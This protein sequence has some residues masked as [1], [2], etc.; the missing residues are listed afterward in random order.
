M[1][2]PKSYVIEVEEYNTELYDDKLN[3]M[4]LS[5]SKEISYFSTGDRIIEFPFNEDSSDNSDIL[6]LSKKVTMQ[7]RIVYD[8]FMMFGDVG[9]LNDFLILACGSLFGFF[10]QRF[11]LASLVE[12][13][14][15]H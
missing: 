9:G 15:H 1:N 7:K 10:S 3:F 5:N 2:E 13:L 8:V 12:S 14:F 11:M 4:D 6:G